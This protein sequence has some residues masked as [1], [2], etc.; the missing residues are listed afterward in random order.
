[1]QHLLA[2]LRE[3]I[4]LGDYGPEGALESEADLGRRYE[5]S[6][7]TVRQALERLRDEGLVSSRKGAGWSV[8]RSAF[9][10]QLALGSFQHAASALEAAGVAVSRAVLEYAFVRCPG[11]VGIVLGVEANS[12]VLRVSSVRRTSGTPLDTVTE[13]LPAALAG[14]ISRSDAEHPGIWASILG[15]GHRI[16]LVRQSIAAVEATSTTAPIL[17]V[18]IGAPLLHVRRIAVDGDG[19]ILAL[20][21][22]RYVGHR[23]RLDVEFRGWPATSATE[24]PGVTQVPPS[25]SRRSATPTKKKD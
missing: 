18:P 15:Q 12:D 20:S 4:A 5:V 16:V 22:H 3:R 19:R 24:P 10:Q 25:T 7:I 23:F 1:M 6:R 8:T 14:P 11:P 2:E 21:D 9:G 17:A 13:W